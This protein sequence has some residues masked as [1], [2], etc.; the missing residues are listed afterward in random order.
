MAL[1]KT[2]LKNRIETELIAEGFVL[3]GPHAWAVKYA[4]AIA[5]AIVDEIQTNAKAT[6][7]DVPSNDSHDLNIV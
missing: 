2:S 6:G 4:R 3:T 7:V 5:N 1:S